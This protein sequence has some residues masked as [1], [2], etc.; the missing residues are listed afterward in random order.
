ME[1]EQRRSRELA[2]ANRKLDRQLNELRI[3]A[4]DD[5]RLAKELSEQCNTLQIKIKTLRRQLEE[6][7]SISCILLELRSMEK[8]TYENVY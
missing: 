4:D 8:M 6:A 1:A 2:A 5:N 7:V 3:Q